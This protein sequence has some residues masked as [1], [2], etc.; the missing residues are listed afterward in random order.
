MAASGP[1]RKRPGGEVL[2]GSSL[3]GE[4][5]SARQLQGPILADDVRNHLVANRQSE[6]YG[7]YSTAASGS[8]LTVARI[9]SNQARP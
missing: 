2:T 8:S 5:L 7:A 6:A 3:I 9:F 1:T 4:W